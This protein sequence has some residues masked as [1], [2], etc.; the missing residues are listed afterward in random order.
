MYDFKRKATWV[1]EDWFV[2]GRQPALSDFTPSS[3][4]IECAIQLT[5]YRKLLLLNGYENVSRVVKL[6]VFHPSLGERCKA[7]DLD[8]GARLNVGRTRGAQIA[9]AALG[10]K[11]SLLD[12]V[13][14]I[15]AKREALLRRHFDASRA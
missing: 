12:Y 4:L 7:V 10:P 6:I 3:D 11:L 1:D 13:D 15:F 9:Q 8:L 2:E 14:F 5:I